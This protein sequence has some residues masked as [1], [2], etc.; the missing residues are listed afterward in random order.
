MDVGSTPSKP[1]HASS[2]S[3]CPRK[4]ARISIPDRRPTTLRQSK[5]F[6]YTQK[7]VDRPA[8]ERNK[9]NKWISERKAAGTFEKGQA[10]G[11][12]PQSSVDIDD[13]SFLF[14]EN[15]RLHGQV[16]HISDE[17]ST[18]QGQVAH[19]RGRIARMERQQ[20]QY[21]IKLDNLHQRMN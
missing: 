15:T 20:E 4:T 11:T 19:T 13:L 5:R 17:L 14:E 7:R 8:W 21:Q 6:S 3:R 1:T 10:S 9:V 2:P 16:W 12:T 18:M